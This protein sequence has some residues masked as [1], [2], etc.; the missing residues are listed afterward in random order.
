MG[1]NRKCR[2]IILNEISEVSE[3][4]FTKM[5]LPRARYML[6]KA[7]TMTELK[8]VSFNSGDILQII[9]IIKSNKNIKELSIDAQVMSVSDEKMGGSNV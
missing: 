7:Q 3:L 5:T 6:E 8:R 9:R 4:D 1:V 2:D